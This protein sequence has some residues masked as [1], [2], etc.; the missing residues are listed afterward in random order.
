[1]RLKQ[2]IILLGATSAI[3]IA[4]LG[5]LYA[6]NSDEYLKVIAQNTTEMLQKLDKI[7]ELINGL[8]EM[9]LAW[10]T[11]MTTDNSP[12]LQ[13]MQTSLTQLGD[14][15]IQGQSKQQ[16]MLQPVNFDLLNND[17]KNVYNSNNGTANA[18]QSM[19]NLNYAN[20][21]TYSTLLG[22]PY[23]AKDPRNKAGGSQVNAAYNYIKNAAA[24][25]I[26]H[27]VPNP[28]WK[29][30]KAK[31]RYQN[32][33]NTVLA[34]ESFDG[35]IL[36]NQLA[37]GNQLNDLQKT[38]VTQASDPSAW[39][40]QVASEKI[41]FVLRQILL[42]QSQLFILMTQMVQSQKQMVTA[43]AMTNSL[44]I[45]INQVNENMMI[46]NAQ[47]VAPSND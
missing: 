17:G 31:T 9:V 1:M 37:D 34:V 35:Y 23:F 16:S 47:G 39:I 22:S 46:S 12:P 29:D 25:N 18:S 41:G 6:Q 40:A 13:T 21:L 27:P 11:P 30:G 15:V 26:Y 36:S 2:L 45:A 4:G 10:I 5:N 19:T 3:S 32:Y 20:D 38:L 28:S 7:P 24:L 14:L 8:S 33:F 44:L 43:Q 42:Y